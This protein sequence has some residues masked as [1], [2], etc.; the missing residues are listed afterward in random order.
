MNVTLRF[1]YLEGILVALAAFALVTAR[2]ETAT[3]Y[4]HALQGNHTK[5]VENL[6]W[7]YMDTLPQF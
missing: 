1:L 7:T 6:K 4:R 5:Y 3:K 2:L